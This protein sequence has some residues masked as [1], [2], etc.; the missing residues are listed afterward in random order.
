MTYCTPVM[1]TSLIIGSVQGK[2][3]EM[4]YDGVLYFSIELRCSASSGR[5]CRWTRERVQNLF[6]ENSHHKEYYEL[7]KSP[8]QMD[9]LDLTHQAKCQES[10]G[11]WYR[12]W[13]TG[14]RS[15]FMKIPVIENIMNHFK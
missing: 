6:H 9:F 10:V 1:L 14:W 2:C 5:L 11:A 3:D 8:K 13:I 4:W 12:S 15:C 7:L